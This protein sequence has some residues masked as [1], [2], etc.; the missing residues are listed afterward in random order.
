MEIIVGEPRRRRSDAEKLEILV[1]AEALGS[2]SM[3]ARRHGISPSQVFGWRKRL[4]DGVLTS[5]FPVTPAFVPLTLE[6]PLDFSP[7]TAAMLSSDSPP[8]ATPAICVRVGAGI[9]MR[10]SGHADP[11]LASAIA[12]ALAPF[13]AVR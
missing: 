11:A 12:S 10:V 3:V 6:V 9:E 8:A 2:V 13:A 1:E 5:G 7:P 4:R